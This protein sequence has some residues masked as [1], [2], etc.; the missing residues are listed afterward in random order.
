MS[1]PTSHF[2]SGS[3]FFGL[4][5]LSKEVYLEQIFLLMYYGGF[6]YTEGYN[7]PVQYRMWFIRR[8]NKEFERSNGEASKAVHQNT[9]EM[10]MLQGKSRMQTPAR[11]RRFT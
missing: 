2:P 8:I 9:P 7:L 6:T 10:N 1:P 3:R 11:L 4:T 5:Q